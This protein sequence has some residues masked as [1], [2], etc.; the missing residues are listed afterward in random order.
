MEFLWLL[1]QVFIGYHLMVPLFFFLLFRLKKRTKSRIATVRK[2]A[3][4]YGLIVTAYEETKFLPQVVNSLLNLNYDNYVIYVV[5]DKCDVTDLQ[6]SDPRV[7]ILRPEKTLASNV[8]SH[9][10]AIHRFIRAHEV[11]AIIDSDNMVHPEFLNECNRS[12][13]SGYDVVQGL[14]VAKNTN[15]HYA[16]LDA[17]RDI[18]YHFY[19]GEV[20]FHLGSSA[21]LAGSGM[22]MKTAL[23]VDCMAA[24]DVK[25]AGFDKV[26]QAELV[27]RGYRISFNGEAIVYDGKTAYADQLVNQRAR[28]INT[29]FKYLRYG[30]L[31][32]SKGIVNRSL[33][34]LL[35]GF[36]LLRPPLFIFLSLSVVC[37]LASFFLSPIS[38]LV[39]L[40]ALSL[41]ILGFFVALWNY[42]TNK[43]IY[44]SLARIPFFV[45]HQFRALLHARSANKRSVATKHARS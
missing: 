26:L 20:L 16:A 6:F 4:D 8:G 40:A 45:F 24:V 30:F 44:Q 39:W 43:A 19:D 3:Y 11:F 9:F 32:L 10:Y 17:A 2:Q 33:N 36:I 5:A 12:F 27:L 7:V 15:T 1:F 28:W 14:R 42:P 21:T 23:Y 29:W 35:F 37:M 22:A 13:D 34:Q 18:Y 31:I 38:G 41:F 25:G